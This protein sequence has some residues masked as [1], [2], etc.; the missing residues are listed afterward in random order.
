MLFYLIINYSSWDWKINL[1]LC[2]WNNLYLILN[3]KF[4][5]LGYFFHVY[6]VFLR[7]QEISH[8]VGRCTKF[9]KSGLKSWLELINS[10]FFWKYFFLKSTFILAL[11]NSTFHRYHAC[12]TFSL[13]L[14]LIIFLH[15][16]DSRSLPE[17]ALL[18]GTNPLRK[19][20]EVRHF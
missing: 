6:M 11:K 10:M 9:K 19:E 7:D 5:I 16:S 4:I 17:T 8:V 1:L 18:S 20:H 12:A 14:L 15:C 13:L 3:K 2:W